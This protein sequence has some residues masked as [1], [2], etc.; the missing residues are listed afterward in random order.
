M[1]LHAIVPAAGMGRR[2]GG[3]ALGEPKS[4]LQVAGRS[5][6]ARAVAALADHGVSRLTVVLG[7]RAER[8]REALGTR[9]GSLRIDYACNADYASTEHGYSLYRAR[10]SWLHG[11]APVLFMDA[12]NVF[13]PALLARLLASTQPD[14]VL[15]DPDLDSAERDEELVLGRDGR[16]TGFVRGRAA[17]FADCAGGF[18]GMNRFSPGYMRAL[19]DYMGELFAREGRGFKYERVFHRMIH[20]R[21]LAP[22]YLDTGG[23]GWVNVNHPRD[24]ERAT[25]VLRAAEQAATTGAGKLSCRAG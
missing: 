9:C 2:L 23:L 11:C 25:R 3:H 7:Y 24:V 15:V 20:E 6:L 18:V 12:D 1:S 8:V 4:L 13:E 10:E 22:A 21:G 19:F 17:D 14:C 16:V 5:I